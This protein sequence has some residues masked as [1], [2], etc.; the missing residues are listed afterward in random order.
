MRR[1]VLILAFG[2]AAQPALALSCMR[3]DV[4]RDFQ[5][6]EASEDTWIVVSGRLGFDRSALPGGGSGI[7]REREVAAHFTGQSLTGDGFTAPFDRDITLRV[8]C[9]G[10]WC[11]TVA[12]GEYLAFLKVEDEDY[13]MIAGP[14]PA[15]LHP[16]PTDAMKADVTR[17][18]AEGC[19]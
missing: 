10:P 4:V 13:T 16:D 15:R 19:S 7:E 2:L 18:M 12:P 8:T 14:C 1:L 17:C 11:G 6:A 9:A 3:P 5:E